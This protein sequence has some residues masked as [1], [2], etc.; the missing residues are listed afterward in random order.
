MTIANTDKYEN[1]PFFWRDA[2][3]VTIVILQIIYTLVKGLN[4]EKITNK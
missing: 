2:Q 4:G 3:I 1:K